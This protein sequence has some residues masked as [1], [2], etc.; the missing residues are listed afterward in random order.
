MKKSYT[1]NTDYKWSD[2]KKILKKKKK[3]QEKLT[4]EYWG[5]TQKRHFKI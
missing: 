2:Q 1:A 5:G 4:K 3:N